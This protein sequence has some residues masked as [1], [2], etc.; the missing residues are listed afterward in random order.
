[1]ILFL[2]IDEN[3]TRSTIIAPQDAMIKLCNCVH[4][5]ESMEEIAQIIT[6]NTSEHVGKVFV[7]EREFCCSDCSSFETYPT[8]VLTIVE[9]TTP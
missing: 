5:K 9:V 2:L 8:S 7:L 3:M 6:C 1:M 4:T